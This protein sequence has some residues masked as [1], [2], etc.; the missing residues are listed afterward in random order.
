LIFETKHDA[1]L[2]IRRLFIGWTHARSSSQ[3]PEAGMHE[4]GFKACPIFYEQRCVYFYLYI[5][6]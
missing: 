4:H 1:N 5:T 6:K 2:L 3:D